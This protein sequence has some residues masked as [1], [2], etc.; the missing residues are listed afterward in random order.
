MD[1]GGARG[2]RAVVSWAVS[3][4]L[5]AGA[6]GGGVLSPSGAA[7][8]QAAAPAASGRA[9]DV[10]LSLGGA[11]RTVEAAGYFT[12]VVTSYRAASADPAVVSA[13]ASGSTVTLTARGAGSTTVTVT[14]ANA[15]G[16]AAQAFA[17]KV[18]PAGCVVELGALAAGSVTTKTGS[19][20]R[21][22][23]CRSVH[24]A[25]GQPGYS[26]RYYSFTVTEPLEAWF[27]LSS[28]ESRRLYLLEG[29]GTGGRVLDSAGT[30][31]AASASLWEALQ[32]GA[33][34]LEATT[35]YRNREGDFSVSIDSMAL[36]PPAACTASLGTLA[37]GSVTA[38]TGS[39][40]RGD[41]CRSVHFPNSRSQRYFARYYAFTVAEPLEAWFRLSG[42]QGKYL[43]LLEGAG[44]GGV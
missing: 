23:G 21:G 34:T 30:P 20:V 9:P 13:S 19:W 16:S 35:Y 33:Y 26:A 15:G 32:P 38:K 3:V 22:D 39:W 14:A 18:L 11:A 17:V 5:F 12:G 41:G 28:S 1:D 27:R 25:A 8:G 24:R 36:S 44:A 4:A 7:S 10:E 43:H 29:A 40:D 42:A 2:R 6:L 31:R 37:A